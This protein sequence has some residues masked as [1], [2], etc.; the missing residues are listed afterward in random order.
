MPGTQEGPGVASAGHEL[1]AKQGDR[2]LVGAAMAPVQ[3]V[4]AGRRRRGRSD[5]GLERISAAG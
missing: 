4:R 3:E 2:A 1:G 5:F